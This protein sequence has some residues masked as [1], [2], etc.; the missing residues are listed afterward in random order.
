MNANKVSSALRVNVE[1]IGPI[2]KLDATLSDKQNLIFARNGTGKSFIA[3]ALRLLDDDVYSQAE[4]SQLPNMLVSEEASSGAAKF[5]LYE[6]ANCIASIGLNVMTGAV[7]RADPSY[8]FHVF[9]ED[10]IDEHVRNKLDTLNG[11][12]THEIVIGRDTGDIEEKQVALDA[13]VIKR[14]NERTTVDARFATQKSKLKDDFS[15][16]ASLGNFKKLSADNYFGAIEFTPD[17][18]SK[19]LQ[20]LLQQYN[21]FKSLPAEALPPVEVQAFDLLPNLEVVVDVLAQQTSPANVAEIFKSKIAGNPNFF[22]SGLGLYENDG[23]ECP[24]C[25]QEIGDVARVAISA[26]VAFFSD[27]EAKHRRKLSELAVQIRGLIGKANERKAY[28]GQQRVLFEE[29]KSYFPSFA[30]RTPSSLDTAFDGVISFLRDLVGLIDKKSENLM[31]AVGMPSV[32]I[33]S[34]VDTATRLADENAKLYREIGLVIENST[35]ERKSIQNQAC[36][37]FEID[38]FGQMRAEISHIRSL[39]EEIKTLI[40]ALA[41]LKRSR[42]DKASARTRVVETFTTLL[43]HFFGEK[44]TFDEGAFKVRRSYEEIK[45]GCDRTLSDGEKSVMAFCYYIAQCHLKVDAIADYR[46]LYFVV[47]DPVSS[48]SFDYI[49]SI[50]QCLKHL[51]IDDMGAISL[52]MAP[53]PRPKMLILTHNNYFYN[54]CS[55]NHIVKEAGLFQLI[56]GAETHELRI[57]KAFATPHMLQLRDVHRVSERKLSPDHTTANSIR[58]VIEGM[59]KFCRPDISQFEAFVQFIVGEGLEIKSVLI[60]DLC[61]GGKFSDPPHREEELIEAS[62]EAVDVVKKFAPGQLVFNES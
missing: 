43:R 61:H 23:K 40:A 50:S 17:G 55:T 48:L 58:S 42:G 32:T 12:I 39:T 9:S 4:E 5:E 7:T 45:R 28:S 21:R 54:V 51:R 44:Y 25:T 59:W 31:V 16:A 38:F 1:F 27:E 24:F 36:E 11:E 19:L 30:D 2:M 41:E 33:N 52:S 15:I 47:D 56:A 13:L 22:E 34:I 8:I 29:L 20:Q 14:D 6:G 62:I 26:Y 57:Q 35:E 3:R 60:N 37:A 49:Y 18:E 46:K 10:Y 53:T